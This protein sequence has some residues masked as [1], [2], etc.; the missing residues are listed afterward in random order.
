MYVFVVIGKPWEEPVVF[1]E[2]EKAE[3]YCEDANGYE[4]LNDGFEY[5][6]FPC[7]VIK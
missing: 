2:R 3:M 1:A 4:E 5:K 7:E 6:V